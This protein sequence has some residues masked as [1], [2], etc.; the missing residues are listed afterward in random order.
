LTTDPGLG[1]TQRQARALISGPSPGAKSRYL[2]HNP[3]S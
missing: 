1:S 3:R 2:G